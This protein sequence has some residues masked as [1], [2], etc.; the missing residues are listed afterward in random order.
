MTCRAKK[1][2]RVVSLTIG[3]PRRK[4]TSWSPTT[5]TAPAASVATV[6]AQKRAD[7]R[8]GDNR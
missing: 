4:R 6:V 3:P 7:S 2:P 5:G 8:G 1:R